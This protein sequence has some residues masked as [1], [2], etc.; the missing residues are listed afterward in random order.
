M[1]AK[2]P[3]QLKFSFLQAGSGNWIFSPSMVRIRF[4][5]NNSSLALNTEANSQYST[6]GFHLMKV[7]SCRYSVA[8]PNTAMIAR[9]T[10]SIACTL[11]WRSQT[12]AIWPNVA[13]I[14]TAVAMRIGAWLGA[15]PAPS[16]RVAKSYAIESFAPAILKATKKRMT[17]N[18]SK[19]NFMG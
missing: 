18:R 13:M 8:P 11:R 1:Q 7:Y 15:M 12:Q 19:R 10:H 14:A 16:Q 5:W 4:L 17:G 9:L 3:A 2:N 6:V